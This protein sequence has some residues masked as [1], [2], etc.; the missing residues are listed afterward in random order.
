MPDEWGGEIGET[1]PGEVWGEN[2]PTPDQSFWGKLNTF[3][4]GAVDG[5][6]N[7][8]FIGDIYG[9]GKKVVENVGTAAS[10]AV[11]SVTS[12]TKLL[13]VVLVGVIVIGGIYVLMMGKR[14]KAVV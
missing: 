6:V 3:F 13:P 1:L 8:S 11:N 2:L 4:D 7:H 5:V 12:I 14:G 10:S 9:Q